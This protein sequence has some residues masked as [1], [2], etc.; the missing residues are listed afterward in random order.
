MKTISI[1]AKVWVK[2][3][4]NIK[5]YLYLEINEIYLIYLRSF[6]LNYKISLNNRDVFCAK[7]RG[8]FQNIQIIRKLPNL[9]ISQKVYLN[10]YKSI[11]LD[12]PI[13]ELK[14]IDLNSNRNICD[15]CL[16]LLGIQ[17]LYMVTSNDY[18]RKRYIANISVA[19]NHLLESCHHP[20]KED[21]PDADD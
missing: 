7:L 4:L 8:L 11:V 10:E 16:E 20:G 9:S 6:V 2:N 17:F 13:S 5:L 15:E 18:V 14:L 3:E 19:L 21:L 12:Y 1:I